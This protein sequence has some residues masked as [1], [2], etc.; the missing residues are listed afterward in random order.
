MLIPAYIDEHLLVLNK[1]SGL[2]CV[3][4]RGEDKQDCL[5]ARAQQQWPDALV[6]HRLDQPTSGLVVMARSL[7]VQR[8][9][10]DAFAARAVRKRY[11]AVVCGNPAAQPLPPEHALHSAMPQ[12][13][14]AWSLVD[15]PL[16]TDWERRPLQRVDWEMGKPSQTWWRAM[17]AE[18]AAALPA[19]P[20]GSTRLWLEP[21]TGRTHQLRLHMQAIGHAMLGDGLYASAAVQTMAPRLLLQ[22]QQLGFAHPVTGQWLDCRLVADF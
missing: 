3:P 12:D 16:I 2:L 15:L 7:A 22:A 4:G 11:T 20:A 1:P 19:I 10:G 18:E 6:V 21:L 14:H 17:D 8:A 5:S 13:G 9:L